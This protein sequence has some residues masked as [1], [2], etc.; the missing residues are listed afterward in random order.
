MSA[1]NKYMAPLECSILNTCHPSLVLDI[2]KLKIHVVINTRHIKDRR[3]VILWSKQE[4]LFIRFI[5]F[6]AICDR[7]KNTIFWLILR[8]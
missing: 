6:G 4:F 2:M 1:V 5:R 3:S 7:E 8:C